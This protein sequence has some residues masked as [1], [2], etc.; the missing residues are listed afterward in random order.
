[1]E[2]SFY[3]DPEMAVAR[4][5]LRWASFAYQ[6]FH[7]NVKRLPLQLSHSPLVVSGFTKARR[8]G[9]TDGKGGQGEGCAQSLTRLAGISPVFRK[10][11]H[12][13]LVSCRS[14][15][16][17]VPFRQG[18]PLCLCLLHL[19]PSQTGKSTTVSIFLP[20]LLRTYG[21]ADHTVL[22]SG[23]GLPPPPKQPGGIAWE[24]W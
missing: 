9:G 18:H 23:G 13:S 14:C 8:M 2:G 7:S 16:K 20:A 17:V 12:A 24:L 11:A 15:I 22:L 4:R 10:A 1:V 19:M 3:L 5:I 6:H 21:V